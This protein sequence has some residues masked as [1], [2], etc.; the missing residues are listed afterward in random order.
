MSL[1]I[2][3][4]VKAVVV[5]APGG[6]VIRSSN[7]CELNPF[8]RPPLEAALRMK[9]EKGASVTVLSMGPPSCAFVLHEAIA[10]GAARGILVSDPAL[11]GS[12]TLATSA[13]L[14][15]ALQKLA[16][17]DLVLFGTRSA[18]GDTGHVGPQTAVLLDLPLVGSVDLIEKKGAGLVV[19]RT[20]DGFR[21]S[22]EVRL[23]AALT[24]HPG[25][26]EPRDVPLAGIQG[27]FERE[28]VETW[29]LSNLGLS[30]E[31]VGEKGSPTRVAAISKADRRRKCK[32]LSG[33]EEEQA[34]QVAQ[35]LT[36]WGLLE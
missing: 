31:Q 27:A 10:M 9:E 34:E 11:A 26:S 30:A 21:E 33:S 32:F 6:R 5:G 1:K 16:P 36:E 18:D 17:F 28:Q 4:C 3:V 8:D 29:S 15:A 20:L 22:F 7:S 2:I 13:A 24:I 23:P 14:G 19:E 35:R 12:D 25:F